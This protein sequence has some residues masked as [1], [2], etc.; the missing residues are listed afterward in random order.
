MFGTSRRANRAGLFAAAVAVFM[1]V[2]AF[3]QNLSFDIPA[4]DLQV[5][6]DAYI[7]Q[8][9]QD[10]LYRSDYLKGQ[11]SKGV[12]GEMSAE[13]ALS[14]ILAGTN[15]QLR[16]DESGAVVVFP[17]EAVAGGASKGI[18]GTDR[19]LEEVIVTATAISQI[20]LETRTATR[21]GADPMLIPLS[22]SSVQAGLLRQQQVRDLTEVLDNVSG[23][24]VTQ[25]G[26]AYA[27]GFEVEAARNGVANGAAATTGDLALRPVVATERVEVVK[28]PEQIMQGKVGGVGGI[29]NV[30]TKIPTEDDY[31]YLG[32]SV[33][34]EGYWRIDA[35][36]NGTLVKG[37]YG[38]LMGQVIGSIQDQGEGPKGILGPSQDF[39]SGGLRWTNTEFGSDLSLAYEY[40]SRTDPAFLV[41]LGGN[42]LENGAPEYLLGD[43]L[44]EVKSEERVT[45]IHYQQRIAGTWMADVT[46]TYS[47]TSS[48]GSYFS[49]SGDFVDP[50]VLV[51]NQS[52]ESGEGDT[53][54]FRINVNGQF[55][56]GPVSH[57]LLLGY[58]YQTISFTTLSSTYFGTYYT[59]IPTY[60]QTFVPC[61]EFCTSTDSFSLGFDQS[62]VLLTDQ[63]SWDKWHFLLGVRWISADNFFAYPPFIERTSEDS[64]LPQYGVTYAAT[65]SLSLYA[66]YSQGYQAYPG[67]RDEDGNPL[68]NMKYAQYEAGV[69]VLL[70]G[71]Q[72]ALTTA[73]YQL[74]E[75][76]FAVCEPGSPPLFLPVCEQ[77]PAVTTRGV[78]F[79][80]AG[81]PLPGL[82][83]RATYAYMEITDDRTDEVPPSGYVP[84]KFSLW[85]QY[86]FRRTPGSGWWAGGGVT[87]LDAPK[88]PP[89]QGE[90]AGNAVFNLSAGYQNPHW[91]AILGVKNVGGSEGYETYGTGP[92]FLSNYYTA[93]RVQDREYRFDLGYRF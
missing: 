45:E 80:I 52:G 39:Y 47:D 89:E 50:N 38:V 35:D 56:T 61:E 53:E 57:R 16:R 22:V 11:R 78:D 79:E 32:G 55:M 73:V 69:K 70:L 28:G 86:W 37:K 15:L 24:T 33:G 92:I 7:K 82:E 93:V 4:G 59:D 66:S 64:T 88:R 49:Y 77:V 67:L 90:W 48:S 81:Q 5:V 60:T 68:D 20:S 74:E 84:N 83:V 13:Q 14:A 58:D 26:T 34:S 29:Y 9:G 87:A 76:N 27:R 6:L 51:A 91:Q 1:A 23:I 12:K 43:R 10:V 40:N 65:P 75:T 63:I 46:Y 31:A 8:T 30:V 44:T 17:D 25:E 42:P 19:E 3:A 41:P 18:A 54:T 62:G 36:V 2:T 71:D 72:L 85:S 21:L